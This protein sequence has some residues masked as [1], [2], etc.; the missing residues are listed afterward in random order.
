MHVAIFTSPSVEKG[1]FV[2]EALQSA[3]EIIA[4]DCG[5]LSA[6]RLHIIPKVVLGDLD[7][8]N[9]TAIEK[10][11]KDGT[12]FITYPEGKDETDTELAIRYA[13]KTGAKKISLIGGIAGNRLE[14][15]VANISLTYNRKV[16]VQLIN[17]PSKAWAVQGPNTV[18]VSG[19]ADDLL[20][21]LPLTK[22]VNGIETTDLVYPLSNESLYF[23]V[24]RG[25][26][27]VFKQKA[28]LVKFRSGVLLFIHT[29]PAELK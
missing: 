19:K 24:P 15:T 1:A 2:T 16:S 4:A 6:L 12:R 18:S 20:S 22:T 21:L 5:A 23:G 7:S 14:H 8:L 11:K 10:L 9:K 17:G 28:V 13:I 27:N 25:I 3:D 29:N 26:S